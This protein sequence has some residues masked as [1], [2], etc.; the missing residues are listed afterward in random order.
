MSDRAQAAKEARQ[1]ER[2]SK[3]P[4]ERQVLALESIEDLLRK[5]AEDIQ[6]VKNRPEP[7][8]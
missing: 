3:T 8:R 2:E 1:K 5:I 7:R 4:E 6:A